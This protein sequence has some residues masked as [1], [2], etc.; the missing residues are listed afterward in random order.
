MS[1][2]AAAARRLRTRRAGMRRPLLRVSRGRLRL[3][4]AIAVL[5][6]LAST[7]GWLLLRD[8]S[9]VSI[10][11]V[12]VT[13]ETGPDGAAIRA[14]LAAAARRMTTLDFQTGPLR[15]AVSRFP[16]V[17]G[18]QVKTRFPHGV[19]IDVIEMLPVAAVKFPGGEIVATSGGTLLPNVRVTGSLP[20]ITLAERPIGEQLGQGW[21]LGAARL[22]GAA[23]SAMLAK[24]TEVMTVAGHGLVAQIREGPSVYF[25]DSSD[26]SAK[27]S[28]AAAVLADPGSQGASYIDVT[29][30]DRPAAGV[31]ANVLGSTS[32]TG[33]SSGTSGTGGAASTASTGTTGGTSSTASTAG[34][35]DVSGTGTPAAG[36]STGG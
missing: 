23:P 29:D 9:F 4:I 7:G 24:V 31:A 35:S 30:P 11:H 19:V 28:A 12:T 15:A 18:L 36:T 20:L 16:E 2:V 17:K 26:L 13:G 6:A 8:S 25:G 33:A 3:L 21:A 14:A 34:P 1:A 22:L 5:G 27:W 10:D 32:G